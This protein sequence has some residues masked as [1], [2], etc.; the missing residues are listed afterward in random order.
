MTRMIMMKHIF[1]FFCIS[2]VFVNRFP[3]ISAR[4]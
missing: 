1:I 2:Y 3:S 4:C